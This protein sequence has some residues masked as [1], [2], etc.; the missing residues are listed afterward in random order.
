M[1]STHAG[2]S[3]DFILQKLKWSALKLSNNAFWDGHIDRTNKVWDVWRRLSASF[4]AQWT[5]SNEGSD[6]KLFYL[7]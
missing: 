3:V 2:D 1:T 5:S 6:V 7:I 4:I